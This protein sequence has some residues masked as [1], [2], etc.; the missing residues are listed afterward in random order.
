M[1]RAELE[2]RYIVDGWYLL[3]KGQESA[4][5]YNER[6]DDEWNHQNLEIQK[7]IKSLIDCPRINSWR[8]LLSEVL[9]SGFSEDEQ[10]KILRCSNDWLT[11]ELESESPL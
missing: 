7:Y 10:I 9:G 11:T 2:K 3:P 5:E 6:M 8:D 1:K 4:S